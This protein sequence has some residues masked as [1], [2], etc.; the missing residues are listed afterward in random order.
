MARNINSTA[1]EIFVLQSQ[2]PY[3]S[4][5][6]GGGGGFLG[7]AISIG[8]NA[9]SYIGMYT[10]SVGLNS[11]AVAYG[12]IA[13][14][15]DTK[16]YGTNSVVVGNKSLNSSDSSAI[17]GY[18]NFNGSTSGGYIQ[19]ANNSI[20][21][22]DGNVLYPFAGDN[23]HMEYE[24]EA[25]SSAE[26]KAYY[27][28]AEKDKLYED[29]AFLEEVDTFEPGT[30]FVRIV[31]TDDSEHTL[32][33]SYGEW[34]VADTESHYKVL[35]NGSN[36]FVSVT[37]NSNFI[38]PSTS[39]HYN[40]NDY[41]LI[42][43][44]INSSISGSGAH[45]GTAIIASKDSE[46]AGYQPGSKL[47]FGENTQIYNSPYTICIGSSCKLKQVGR[48]IVLGQENI[49]N[50]KFE[51]SSASNSTVLGHSNVVSTNVSTVI[52]TGNSINETDGAIFG[53][54]NSTL[55]NSGSVS[56]YGGGNTY[57]GSGYSSG[58]LMYGSNNNAVLNNGSDNVIVGAYNKISVGKNG[59]QRNSVIG[60]SNSFT[61][62]YPQH[63]KEVEYNYS[64]YSTFAHRLHYD[65]PF[66]VG[67]VIDVQYDFFNPS[68]MK[69]EVQ[70]TYYKL[71]DIDEEGYYKWEELLSRPS[72]NL[73]GTFKGFYQRQPPVRKIKE[74][75]IIYGRIYDSLSLNYIRVLYD[76]TKNN[77]TKACVK[78][79]DNV[80]IPPTGSTLQDYREVAR[81][82]FPST[83]KVYI[84]NLK[85][86]LE[87]P[88]L[89]E[90]DEYTIY[91]VFKS[92]KFYKGS[93]FGNGDYAYGYC[94]IYVK[95]VQESDSQSP[96]QFAYCLSNC[97]YG[98]NIY[99]NDVLSSNDSGNITSKAI[100]LEQLEYYGKGYSKEQSWNEMLGYDNKN[101]GKY[102][103]ILGN[104]NKTNGPLSEHN[105]LLGNN[106]TAA[107]NAEGQ[108]VL[109]YYNPTDYDCDSNLSEI[110]GYNGKSLRTLDKD[111]NL[112]VNGSI[113]N[114]EHSIINKN[115]AYFEIKEFSNVGEGNLT[116]DGY[117]ITN[118]TDVGQ[119]IRFIV[120]NFSSELNPGLVSVSYTSAN[121]NNEDALSC[122][123]R[124]GG[125][126][127]RWWFKL[128]PAAQ[129]TYK[130]DEDIKIELKY[131]IYIEP[132]NKI[133]LNSMLTADSTARQN[134]YPCHTTVQTNY[135][136]VSNIASGQSSTA[137]GKDVIASGIASHA[138]GSNSIASGDYSH[139][140][141]AATK[142]IGARAHA[143]GVLTIAS[144]D[145]SH[146]EGHKSQATG[147]AAHAEGFFIPANGFSGGSIKVL[148]IVEGGY[149]DGDKCVITEER[150]FISLRIRFTNPPTDDKNVMGAFIFNK[151]AGFGGTA[152]YD[153]ETD[154]AFDGGA[155]EVYETTNL[156]DGGVIKICRSGGAKIRANCY[157]KASQIMS[158]MSGNYSLSDDL[159]TIASGYGSHAEGIA[160][161]AAGR[162]QHVAGTLNVEDH[163]KAVIVGNGYISQFGETDDEKIIR[164]N[165]Y[166]LDWYGNGWFAGDIAATSLT[167][168]ET[169]LDEDKL[170]DLIK[171]G[172]GSGT[173]VI[174][175]PE[176]EA[177]DTLR[178]I[179]VDGTVYSI[180]TGG[181]EGGSNVSWENAE[182][183]VT[184][185]VD[186]VSKNLALQS[187]LANI[188]TPEV[189]IAAVTAMTDEQKAALRAAL[190]IVDLPSAESEEGF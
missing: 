99:N 124:F 174:A 27:Y 74:N 78:L 145:D 61:S 130:V 63:Y 152:F 60:V 180:P 59:A 102:N 71:L 143:E 83:S 178:K 136:Y 8:R 58:T 133:E 33:Y 116:R 95:V 151:G 90:M 42:D 1:D 146:A 104:F 181:G 160:T 92:P 20:Y 132:N 150:E 98:R 167:L 30:F 65:E 171:G 120:I 141:G 47:L 72:G 10:T 137:F 113:S 17:F 149:Q 34:C 13:Q 169:N 22:T 121:L 37:G 32:Q 106:L 69:T 36:R 26:V 179:S 73:T 185:N 119:Y 51:G 127:D 107:H 175:N 15:I 103:V 166:T 168:G 44:S 114:G 161:I 157:F 163:T 184:L 94:D 125:E 117:T 165:A 50:S 183:G 40:S 11:E 46:I 91:A 77:T 158:G 38:K 79:F 159:Y 118:N 111:G 105:V 16:N 4:G 138:E 48:S 23:I 82:M 189:I 45:D 9:T 19:G 126:Y 43:N 25:G 122:Y 154:S 66:R 128:I 190:G 84:Y 24:R 96:R 188:V 31:A 135:K 187:D 18:N 56:I 89:D 100:S 110:F 75:D 123:T 53:G 21:L 88:A 176:E 155:F 85:N 67:S 177:T 35:D 87:L 144:G 131:P 115:S 3:G 134:M 173:E 162:A 86:V 172:G 170:K 112:W 182:K 64:V 7:D 97:T 129:G 76:F 68:T 2:P 142:A 101:E 164:S 140:E 148:S 139:A 55:S 70:D 39:F 147:W 108:T 12:T 80:Y 29:S 5:G 153:I 41:L 49:I 62:W 186:G 52:G 54:G 93:S 81:R 28:H 6:G 14:G 156:Y 109:G 57:E